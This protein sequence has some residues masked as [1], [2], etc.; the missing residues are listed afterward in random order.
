MTVEQVSMSRTMNTIN[1]LLFFTRELEKTFP[2][3]QGKP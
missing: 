2:N 3:S 1:K